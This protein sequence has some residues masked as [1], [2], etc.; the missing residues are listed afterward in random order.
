MMA[1]EGFLSFVVT[2]ALMV[3]MSAPILLL[4]FLYRDWRDGKLW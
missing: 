1:S 2:A 4:Y 3:T